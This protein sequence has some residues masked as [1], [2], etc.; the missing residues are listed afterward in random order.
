MGGRA[1]VGNVNRSSFPEALGIKL[2]AEPSRW[3]MSFPK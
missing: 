2:E 1:L 3:M